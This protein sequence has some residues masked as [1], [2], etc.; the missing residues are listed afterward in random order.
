M[1]EEIMAICMKKDNRYAFLVGIAIGLIVNLGLVPW[2]VQSPT[3]SMSGGGGGGWSIGSSPLPTARAESITDLNDPNAAMEYA[4]NTLL[5]QAYTPVDSAL[6]GF[7]TTSTYFYA[8]SQSTLQGGTINESTPVR[9]DIAYVDLQDVSG[10]IPA[11]PPTGYAEL[12][13]LDV[14]MII[15]AKT[16]QS[17]TNT[18]YVS[19]FVTTFTTQSGQAKQALM[20]T[21]VYTT[22]EKAVVII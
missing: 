2:L 15:V 10:L 20:D 7:S 1:I 18:A 16:L 3:S 19:G 14:S 4:F 11:M 12:D 21:G 8:T 17:G 9:L 6:I 22:E 13:N 5:G